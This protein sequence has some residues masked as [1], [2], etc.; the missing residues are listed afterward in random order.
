MEFR[1]LGPLE[2]W[3]DGR[4]LPLGGSK[5]RM[6]LA[7]LLLHRNEVV[8]IDRLVDELWTGRPPA[9]AVKVVQVYVSQL[10]KA[11]G[12]RRTRSDDNDVL[13]TRAPGYLLRIGRDELDADR[14]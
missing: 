6:L 4:R 1:I 10:R 8:S 2:V 3:S 7:V 11:L 5:Q 9:T 14:F 12:G 13:V